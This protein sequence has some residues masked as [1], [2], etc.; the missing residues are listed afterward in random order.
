MLPGPTD[1]PTVLAHLEQARG[2]LRSQ[3]AQAIHRKKV[4]EL[5]FAVVADPR[6]PAGTGPAIA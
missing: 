4:P 6:G 2:K 3:V 1:S 5:T